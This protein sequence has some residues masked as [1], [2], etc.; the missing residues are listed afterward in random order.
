MDLEGLARLGI[1]PFAIDKGLGFEERF[2]A[3]LSIVSVCYS[4]HFQLKNVQAVLNDP[5]RM[6][7]KRF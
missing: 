2:V 5:W 1:N 3:Q 7:V 6:I 4:R